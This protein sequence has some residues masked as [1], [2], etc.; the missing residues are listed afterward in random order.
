[1]ERNKNEE[2]ENRKIVVEDHVPPE[3]EES[4]LKGDYRNVAILLFLYILQGIPLGI[5]SAVRILLQN[6]GVSYKEQAIF[7]LA[8]YPFTMKVLWCPIVDALYIKRFGRRKSWLVPVQILIGAFMIVL[9]QNVNEWLGDGEGNKPQII[10][11]TSVFFVLW[12]L[13]ATQDIVVDG[14]CLTMLQRRNVGYAATTNSCGQT[15]GWFIG[16]VILL[17]FESTEFCNKY[18]FSEPRTEGLITLAG[19]LRFWGVIFLITTVFIAIFKKERSELDY[20]LEEH[21]DYGVKKAYPILWKI[22]KLKP[23]LKLSLVLLTAKAGFAACDVVTSLKLIEYGMPKEKAALLAI[24]LVPIQLVLP[25][26]ISR[27]T[28]GPRPM[29][30]Y[31]K[32]FPYRLLMTVVIGLFVFFTPKMKTDDG[33]PFYFYLLLVCIYMV[34]QIP[35]RS[36]YICDMSFFAKISDPLIGGTYMT[37]MNTITNL[38]GSWVQTF[39]LWFVDVI[40]WR[41]CIFDE[42][43]LLS[44]STSLPLDNKC[45][46]KI[47]KE[48]CTKSGGK[49]HTDIEGYYIEIGINVVYGI[50]WFCLIKNLILYLQSLP[51]KE[52]YVLSRKE[53]Q[54]EMVQVNKKE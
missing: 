46:D 35:F 18:I 22:V 24:P 13:T 42:D 8:A 37:L 5:S 52:W 1:M 29:S 26:I 17:V 4:N 39:F 41:R 36:M 19:F 20:E 45:S 7:S 6:R 33:F 25:F 34:Y 30:F 12:F 2:N 43:L 10:L 50:V 44:N 9:A 15:G 38:G 11:L 53:E 32:A 21:P 49:C 31:I 51:A 40:T 23:V 47:E 16:Y 14:W 48:I 3:E 27:Y 54:R 28:A